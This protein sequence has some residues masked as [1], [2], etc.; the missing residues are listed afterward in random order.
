VLPCKNEADSL[1]KIIP[2]IPREVD[3]VIIVDNNSSDKTF[4]IAKGFG[5]KVYSERRSDKDN[6]GYGFAI[7]KGLKQATGDIVAVLDA[8]GSYPLTSIPHLVEFLI[9]KNLDFL[10]CNR[11]PIRKRKHM[12]FIRILGVKILN[13]FIRLLFRYQIKDA[14]TG[15]WIMKKNVL[16]KISLCEGGWNLSLEIKIKSILHPEIKFAERKIIY[17]DRIWGFSKQSLFKTGILHLL[18]LLKL[19]IETFK[20][21]TK[22]ANY[23]KYILNKMPSFYLTTS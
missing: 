8:D 11:L 7:Q 21:L 13:L 5:F 18:Y 14:L 4:E 23:Y 9:K 3:E 19:R 1:S 6:I 10:S 22:I 17:Q 15:M 16:K 2:K 20:L 12:S